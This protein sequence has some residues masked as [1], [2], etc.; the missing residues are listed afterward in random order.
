VAAR[1]DRISEVYDETREPLGPEAADRVVDFLS[2]EAVRKV[3]EVGVGTGRIA[4]PLQ[5]R[6]VDVVG[7][8]LS[9]RMLER[10]KAKGLRNLALADANSLPFTDESFDAALLAH[11]LHLLED[12]RDT[13][14]RVSRVARSM[15]L[16]L[17]RDREGAGAPG[18]SERREIWRAF[19]KASEETGHP[20][21][22][23]SAQWRDR[24]RRETDF[25]RAFPPDEVFTVQDVTVVETLGERVAVLEKRAYGFP[26]EIP[27][28][29]F[30]EILGRL[31]ASVDLEKEYRYRRVER[32]G[33]WRRSRLAEM[34]R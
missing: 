23:P 6:Q 15:M 3:L 16:V 12:P 26:A 1:F 13:V 14:V 34:G 11:V 17:F 25:L 7:V 22:E 9:K 32:L 5:K 31:R 20:L 19:R 30:H 2:G 24:F 8:D 28:E 33:V 4:S 10:A 29:I 27:D 18:D 21:P